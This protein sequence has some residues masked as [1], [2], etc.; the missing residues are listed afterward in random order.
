MEP[1]GRRSV[2]LRR[3]GLIGLANIL[4]ILLLLALLEGSASLLLTAHEIVR[5]PAVP[6]HRHAEHDE[7]LG[8]VNLPG[9]DLPD[10]YGPGVAVRT[11][12]QRFR[13][14]H[15]FTTAVP[16]GRIRI[17]C[18]GDSFTFGYGVGNEDAWCGR[19][20]SLDPRL[21]TVNMG[22]GGYGVDQ[23]YLW[24][25]RD[26]TSLDHDLHLFAV[27]A[28]DFRRMRSDRFMGYGKPL[29]VVRD[30]TLAVA[31]LPVP[32]TSWLTRRRAL[33]GETISRLG[34]VR[35]VRGLFRLDDPS[36]A[37]ARNEGL[38]RQVREAAGRV[39]AELA[40][41]NAAKE[42]RLVLV[43]LP[44]AWDYMGQPGTETWRSFVRDEAER[45]GI[46]FLDMVE[47][48][49]RLQP[50]EVADLYAPNL[51]F[52]VA[53]NAWAAGTIHRRLQPFP[54]SGDVGAST[55][56][57]SAARASTAGAS[58][59]GAPLPGAPLPDPP[60]RR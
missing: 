26:G 19:L 27:L 54:G 25:M 59:G 50:E 42:S 8:W 38:D 4:V 9:V 60:L 1:T 29:L 53:G 17:V 35:A 5:T 18:S 15:D 43:F 20:T 24:Y 58:P 32:R 31:N 28:D 6:E 16:A 11:N 57:A 40:R 12:G 2:R 3:A 48:L 37:V 7:L 34:I 55:A 33:H 44:G 22:L 39:F 14:D 47:E 46:E 10:A 30:D 45:Q 36:A 23:A 52:S 49:R 41:V 51:H 13:N 21:E 56:R